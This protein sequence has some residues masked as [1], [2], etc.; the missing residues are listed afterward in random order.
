[1][2]E[3]VPECPGKAWR[4]TDREFVQAALALKYSSI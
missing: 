4:C 3:I 2:H 1:M